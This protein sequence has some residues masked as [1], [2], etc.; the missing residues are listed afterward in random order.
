MSVT[1]HNGYEPIDNTSQ[2]IYN[3][4]TQEVFCHIKAF[5]KT[6]IRLIFFH[7]FSLIL[8]GIPYL[9]FKAYPSVK[10][11][12]KYKKC[13]IEHADIFL[14]RD[15]HNNHSLHRVFSVNINLDQLGIT[16]EQKYF[17]HQHTKYVWIS[18]RQSFSTYDQLIW[19]NITCN[20]LCTNRSGLTEQHYNEL[21]TLFGP[22]SI[23]IEVKSYWRLFIEE[24]L[25]PFYFFQAFSIIL[26][27]ID[28]YF[29]YAGCVIFLTF[30]S[31]VTSLLQ[32]QK[33]SQNLHD[34]VESSKCH[35][36]AVLREFGN[37]TC[38]KIEPDDV[39]PGDIIVLPAGDYVMPCDAVLITGQCIVNESVLTGESVPVTKSA[40]PPDSD[41]FN[42]NIHKRHV[43][44]SGT[45]VLQTRYYGGENVLAKVVRTGFDTTKGHLVKSILYPAPIN[46]QFYADALKFVYLLFT[47]AVSG[48]AYCLYLYLQRH[49]TVVEIA[50]RVLDIITIVVPPA[51]PAA[52]TVGTVY[53]QTRLKK[54]KIFCISPPRINVCGKIKLAC[55]DKTGTLT[56]DGLDMHSVMPCAESKFGEPVNNV[57][58]LGNSYD[59][60]VRGMATC[61]SLTRIGGSLTGDPLDLNMFEFTKWNLEEPGNDEN[62]RFDMLAPTVV[63][64]PRSET[65]GKLKLTHED[66]N[67]N[68]DECT[69]EVGIIKEFPFSSTAQ[70]MSVICKDLEC[71]TMFAYTKGAPEKLASLCK[72]STLPSNFQEKLSYYTANGFRVIAV[73]FKNLP[74]SF[75][76]REAQKVKR[77]QIECDLEFLGLLIMQNPLKDETEPVIQDL[78]RAHIPTVM[79]TGDNIMTAISVARDCG[80]VGASDD[81]YIVSVIDDLDNEPPKLSL[82]KAGSGS[83]RDYTIIDFNHSSFYCAIDGKTWIKLKSHFQDLLPGFLVRTK[84]FARFQPD[85]KTQVV[86]ALQEL[87]YV[88]AMVGDG[89]NDCGALKAAHVGVSLS[90]EEA[91]VAA[92]FTSG[93][94][95][96][97]CLTRLISE[98]RCSLVTSFALFKY[99]ALYSLIQF[100]TVLILYKCHSILGDFQFLYIDLIITTFL[101]I[102]MGRQGPLDVLCPKRPMSS[103]VSSKNMFPLLLQIFVC[104]LIQLGALYFLYRQKWFE[105]IPPDSKGE[106]IVSWENT[107]LFTVSCYQYIVLAWHFSKGKPYR[108][109]HCF[110]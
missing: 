69:Y 2:D 37:E 79:I 66:N 86:T 103:L 80:M 91:S 77:N 20:D 14:V 40:L 64:A 85:Q 94:P 89:A 6:K 36:V 54:L 50:V 45:H 46:L 48:M 92:P 84:V 49:A 100:F 30:F 76:W 57:G 10:S 18:E 7:I 87:D 99:M 4:E 62:A 15:N 61:H 72:S 25:N 107:V 32:T 44:F 13:C 31:I 8:C 11:R 41:E 58:H 73:A 75:K 108:Y 81:I 21:F 101:A 27:C 104:A 93:I 34:I 23:E 38:L 47:I 56:H 24:I 19:K 53:S 9:I 35:E 97:S 55:F 60:L 110:L 67:V 70:C 3:E 42:I 90:P 28:D 59:V 82:Q 16:G 74:K 29:I 22:N 95:N 71:P 106:I 65:G 52:M 12:V 33:Q 63:S 26:W 98:G 102:S 96:I 1:S 109:D 51:L 17:F 43:L 5:K 68:R 83:S 78:H 105:P 88:V 39:V